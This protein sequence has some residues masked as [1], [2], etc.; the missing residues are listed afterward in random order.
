MLSGPDM[1]NLIFTGWLLA[2]VE[3]NPHLH[4]IPVYILSTSRE[5]ATY[6]KCMNLGAK[7]FYVKPDSVKG[8]AAIV[9]DMF[10]V[11]QFN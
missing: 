7:N 2:V 6:A 9:E 5:N 8:L 11:L 3:P 4:D 10:G 1:N